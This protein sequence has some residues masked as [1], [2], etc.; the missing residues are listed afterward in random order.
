MP[1][2]PRLVDVNAPTAELISAIRGVG[3][4]PLIVGG[5]VR[6]ALLNAVHRS[7]TLSKDLDIEVYGDI[8]AVRDALTRTASVTSQGSSFSMLAVR[9]GGQDY[10]VS[11]APSL[12]VRESSARRDFTINSMAWDPATG[13]LIDHLDG[14]GDLARGILR[15]SSASFADDPLRVLRGV[16]FAGRFGFRFAAETRGQCRELAPRFPEIAIERIWGEWRKLARR[17]TYWPEALTALRDSGWLGAFPEL[18]ATRGVP[19]DPM[20]HSEGDVFVHSGLAAAAAAR[21]AEIHGW[22]ASDREVAVLG[23]LIHDFG[24]VTHTDTAG[25]RITSR[26]HAAAGEAPARSFLERIGAP[27]QLIDRVAPIVREHMSHVAV[28]GRPSRVAVRRLMRR[29]TSDSAQTTIADW[30]RVV[31]ADCAGRVPA[32]KSPANQW[33]SIADTIGGRAGSRI[34]TGEHLK[35]RGLLP[36]PEFGQILSAS[37]LAQDDEVFDSEAGALQWLD[38]HLGLPGLR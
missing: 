33:L 2:L 34:L 6:D 31:D 35:A 32:K 13:E 5:A 3:A 7:T 25:P 29:L 24:K 14:R 30:A 26:G 36:G 22:S 10:D 15:H 1:H 11:A 27:A 38:A 23:A 16:Q 12:D 21:A 8:D 4:R 9:L 18:A 20:W 19:Q 37:L 28:K 17:A